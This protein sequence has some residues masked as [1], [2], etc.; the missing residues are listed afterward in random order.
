M[1]KTKHGAPTPPR[2]YSAPTFAARA[3]TDRKKPAHECI[4]HIP[5]PVTNRINPSQSHATL[6]AGM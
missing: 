3:V 2:I 5:T 4:D 1:K 6:G